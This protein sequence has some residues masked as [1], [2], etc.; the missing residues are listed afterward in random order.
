MSIG[1]LSRLAAR[2]IRSASRLS[3]WR[4]IELLGPRGRVVARGVSFMLQCDNWIT[5]FRMEEF[6]TREPKSLTGS[7]NTFCTTHNILKMYRLC[8]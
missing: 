7:T 6:E 5:Q 3:R 4:L 1:T 2:K 8:Q